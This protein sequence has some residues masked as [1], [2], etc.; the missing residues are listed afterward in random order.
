MTRRR[1][2]GRGELLA[3]CAFLA[4]VDLPLEL[5]GMPTWS[6]NAEGLRVT[7]SGGLAMS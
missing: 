3:L 6:D 2:G 5:L 7:A 1:D 4:P